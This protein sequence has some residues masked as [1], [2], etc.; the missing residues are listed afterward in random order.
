MVQKAKDRYR[1]VIG[2]WGE[3]QAAEYLAKNGLKIL[4]RNY[5]SLEGEIDLIASDGDT[6][7]FVEVKTRTNDTYGFPEEA[8]TE[9]KM[10]HIYGAAEEYLAE[11]LDIEA[12]RIDVIAIQGKPD[13]ADP[14]FEWFKDAG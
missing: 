9:E 4:Q 5:R 12:W 8:V 7:V 2:A 13:E 1:Q 6:L 10:E 3:D 11:H 14:Q